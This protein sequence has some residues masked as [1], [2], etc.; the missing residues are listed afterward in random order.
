MFDIG[1]FV[2]MDSYDRDEI[3]E[4]ECDYDEDR[5]IWTNYEEDDQ[6]YGYYEDVYD[7]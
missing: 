6:E 1:Y 7:W 4:K 5:E 3:E 2:Y